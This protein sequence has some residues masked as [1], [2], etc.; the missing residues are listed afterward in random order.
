MLDGVGAKDR[1]GTVGSR[2]RNSGSE[3]ES[4]S[5]SGTDWHNQVRF[6]AMAGKYGPAWFWMIGYIAI[7][8]MPG[9]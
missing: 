1:D 4:R 6:A 7:K 3:S 2:T 5:P 8:I 9:R